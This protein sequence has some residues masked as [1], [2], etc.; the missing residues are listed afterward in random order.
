[1]MGI[2]LSD[3]FKKYPVRYLIKKANPVALVC[4]ALFLVSFTV[5]WNVQLQDPPQS[6][7]IFI[8]Y[9]FFDAFGTVTMIGFLLTVGASTPP[10]YR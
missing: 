7:F 5:L 10:H 4:L 6:Q 2:K 9:K 1:M 8:I 3:D